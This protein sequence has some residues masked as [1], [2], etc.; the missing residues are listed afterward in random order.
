[1]NSRAR[2]RESE[3]AERMLSEQVRLCDCSDDDDDDRMGDCPDC[4]ASECDE[5]D[6]DCP[7]WYAD[8]MEREA[9]EEDA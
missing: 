5:C 6:E 9:Q 3:I 8:Y 7:S 2:R 1:M 4:G